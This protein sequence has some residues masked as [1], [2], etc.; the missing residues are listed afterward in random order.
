MRLYLTTAGR[1]VGTQAD[2][3]SKGKGWR[4]EEVPTD[5]L[6]LLAYLNAMVTRDELD[7][8]PVDTQPQPSAPLVH[9]HTRVENYTADDIVEFLLDR[10]SVAHVERIFAAIGTRFAEARTRR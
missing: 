9:V 6:G 1:Y 3:K 5:K 7:N 2:A 4:P 8:P 10:A